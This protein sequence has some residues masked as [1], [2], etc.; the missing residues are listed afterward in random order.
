LRVYA[1]EKYTHT[2]YIGSITN[3]NFGGSYAPVITV[4]EGI[5][6]SA[7]L[8]ASPVRAWEADQ[9]QLSYTLG[10][11]AV[12]AHAGAS[13][14]ADGVLGNRATPAPAAVILT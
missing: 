3:G 12:S 8:M 1:T 11:N 10:L 13:D 9:V 4:L 14:D 6:I 5:G 7:A 2:N